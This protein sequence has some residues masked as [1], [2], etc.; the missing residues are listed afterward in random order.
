M[1]IPGNEKLKGILT[2]ILAGGEGVKFRP[3]TYELPKSLIPIR[4]KPLLEHTLEALR[5]QGFSEIYIS[6][7]HLGEKI[8]DYFADGSR[9]NLAIRYLDQG[10]GKRGT[11]Q[12]VLE[13]KGY[14]RQ[15][16]QTELY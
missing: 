13:A 5:D 1:S 2:M 9:W 14:G 11:A 8:K 12:P 6:I 15:K 10:S 4:G 16:G 3:L 7:G